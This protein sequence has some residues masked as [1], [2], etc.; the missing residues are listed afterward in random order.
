MKYWRFAA[1]GL[2][3]AASYPIIASLHSWPLIGLF[4]VA[5]VAAYA[6]GL[7]DNQEKINRLVEEN[8]ALRNHAETMENVAAELDSR[9]H[10]A[11]M[12]L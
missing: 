11:D 2:M 8:A 9:L 7:L 5:V 1:G 4:V 10:D 3:M 6:K 12:Q